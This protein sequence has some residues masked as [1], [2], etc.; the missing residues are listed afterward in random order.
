MCTNDLY[1][2]QKKKA[3]FSYYGKDINADGVYCLNGSMTTAYGSLEAKLRPTDEE[4]KWVTPYEEKDTK[5]YFPK[6][7]KHEFTYGPDIDDSAYG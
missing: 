5:Y 1:K 3:D 4:I 6:W 2:K 7:C